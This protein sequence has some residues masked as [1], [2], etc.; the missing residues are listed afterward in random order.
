MGKDGTAGLVDAT[1]GA[2]LADGS[3]RSIVVDTT[4]QRCNDLQGIA[5]EVARVL[6]DGGRMAIRVDRL[7][8]SRNPMPEVYLSVHAAAETLR[9]RLEIVCDRRQGGI[10]TALIMMLRGYRKQQVSRVRIPYLMWFF[11]VLAMTP[12]EL[13]AV[14]TLNIL[15]L[16]L[17]SLDTTRR[18]YVSCLIVARKAEN[19]FSGR[20]GSGRDSEQD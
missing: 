19:H 18:N 4:F 2:P 20:A 10:G 13:V 7:P 5:T 15:G 16:L 9:S 1:T 11:A 6:K 14:M 17:D 3:V 12:I 8:G